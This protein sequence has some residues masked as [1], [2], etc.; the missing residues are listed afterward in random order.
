VESALELLRVYTPRVR[1]PQQQTLCRASQIDLL[2]MLGRT[3]QALGL[4]RSFPPAPRWLY[5]QARLLHQE[6][7]IEEAE[8]SLQQALRALLIDVSGEESRDLEARIRLLQARIHAEEGRTREA[9]NLYRLLA[10]RYRDTSAGPGILLGYFEYLMAEGREKD[11]EEQL[12]VLAREFPDSPELALARSG[13]GGEKVLYASTPSRL[14]PRDLPM[15]EGGSDGDRDDGARL[16][17]AESGSPE[18]PEPAPAEKPEPAPAEERTSPPAVQPLSSPPP[19]SGEPPAP[20][21]LVQTG[22]FQ[23]RENAQY[24]VRGLQAAG[25]EAEIAE[26]RIG[27]N[28]YYRVVIGPLMTVEQAQAVLMRLKDSSFEGVLLFPE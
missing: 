9:E 22:S 28:L 14:L 13:D 7:L 21:A 11:A 10:S 20:V 19:T 4:L 2:E 16:P 6:G 5:R 23:D 17:A 15:P 3:E 25:F 18:K 1:D 24:M 8:N 12:D 26:K 27:G